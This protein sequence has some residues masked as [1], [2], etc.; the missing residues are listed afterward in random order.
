VTTDLERL[1]ILVHEVRSPV[2]ALA[3]VKEALSGG[4]LGRDDRH[5]LIALGIAA[6]RGIDR[7]VSDATVA[8]VHRSTVDVVRLAEDS[9][10]AATLGGTVVVR[11]SSDVPR[12]LLEVDPQRLR[13]ALDNLVANAVAVSAPGGEVVVEVVGNDGPARISVADSGP[14]VPVEELERIFERGV[15]LDVERPGSG[16]GLSIARAIVRAHGGALTVESRPGEGATFTLTL[17]PSRS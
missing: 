3:A 2:A 14:G 7:I 4:G 17:G 9:A 13:Q 1:A 6:C 15:R 16:L 11:S 5:A 8:S 10:A 12:L